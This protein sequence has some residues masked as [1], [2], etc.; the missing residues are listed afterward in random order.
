MIKFTELTEREITFTNRREDTGEVRM[1]SITAIERSLA[2]NGNQGCIEF[3][4]PLMPE[5]V[6]GFLMNYGIEE[7][8]LARIRPGF[9]A[10]WM[11]YNRDTSCT[12]I[13]GAHRMAYAFMNKHQTIPVK[14]IPFTVWEPCLIDLD[15]LPPFLDP[16]NEAV[17]EDMMNAPSFMP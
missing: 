9:P 6:T 7:H 17:Y 5:W 12:L 10:V 8:R 2:V 11:A 15:T 4:H 13:D 14:I 3:E 16:R 1:F